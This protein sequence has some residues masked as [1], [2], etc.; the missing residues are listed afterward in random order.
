MRNALKL[1]HLLIAPIQDFATLGGTV[2]DGYWRNGKRS[3]T[4][5]AIRDLFLAPREDWR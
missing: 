5:K 4:T 3:Y 1:V 2:N